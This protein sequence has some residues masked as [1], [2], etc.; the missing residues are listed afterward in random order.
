MTT[1]TFLDRVGAAPISWGICEAPGWGMQL[2]VDRVLGEARDLG[3][4][5]FEQGALGWL[6][7]DPD[8]QRAKLASYGMELLGGFVALVL[9]DPAE[10]DAQLA[11]AERVAAAMAA[12][13]GRFFVSC[14]VAA[15]DDWHR[16]EMPDAAWSELF[17]NL[18]RVDEICHAAGLT[19]A[20]H[21]HVDTLI[22]TADDFARFLDSCDVPFCFDTGHLTIGG[23]DVVAIAKEQLDRIGVVHLK[24]VDADAMARERSGELDLMQATQAGLF[25]S[26]GDGIVPVAEVVEVL[27]RAGYDGWYVMET[28]V[29]LT[30]GEPPVGEGPV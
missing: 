28:D 5:A 15:I 21:P 3:L 2:P 16:I 13:G 6:P 1:T 19:Q 24:D 7:P 18:T 29:A 22:E 8:E 30:D 10:R 23:A 25:P 26:L 20:M 14:P 12:T 17:A 4:T 9:H 27:E 11:E